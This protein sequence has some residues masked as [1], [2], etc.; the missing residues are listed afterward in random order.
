[1]KKIKIDDEVF[2]YL[3]NKAMAFVETP[4]DTLRRLFNLNKSPNSTR[5][6]NRRPG[7]RKKRQTNLLELI[8]AGLLR[9][10]QRLHLMDYS[11][12]II[13]GLEGV[14]SKNRIVWNGTSYSMSELARIL[15][16]EQG[17]KTKSVRGPAHWVTEAGISIKSLWE[18]YA[19]TGDADSL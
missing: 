15:L 6:N 11:E 18:R 3:Q 9:D 14:I 8:D 19:K 1:M 12:R 16:N 13:P 7:K 10:G 2:A 5:G 17:Y 4:N